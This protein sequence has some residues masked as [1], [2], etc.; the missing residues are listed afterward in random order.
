MKRKPIPAPG[1]AAAPHFLS[2]TGAL[3]EDAISG[4]QPPERETEPFGIYTAPMGRFSEAAFTRIAARA[5]RMPW[6]NTG[7]S[8]PYGYEPLRQTI[9]RRLR[10]WKEIDCS[11]ENIVITA[12]T[13]QSLA[14]ISSVVLEAGDTVLAEDPGYV[15]SQQVLEFQGRQVVPVPLDAQGLDIRLALRRAPQARAALVSAVKQFPAGITMSLERREALLRWA[16]SGNRWIFEDDS[17]NVPWLSEEAAQ[18]LRAMPMG[19][20][21]VFYMESLSFQIFPG[22][23]TGFIVAPEGF[24]AALAGARMM[25]DR[26]QS[27]YR[28]AL[29]A[30][31]LES[32]SYESYLRR[33]GRQYRLRTAFFLRTASRRLAPFGFVQRPASGAFIVLLLAPG[34]PDAAVKRR[35]AGSLVCRALS[36]YGRTEAKRNGLVLGIGS[37][38]EKE[39]TDGVELIAQACRWVR[40]H[41]AC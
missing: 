41:R 16:A 34:I 9:A 23:C 2:K 27:E 36:G 24:Q 18:P 20:Q 10:Q 31:Y 33:L 14:L 19:A 29:L 6:R 37:F 11:E 8:S 30:E 39:I 7:Y 15:R 40:D 32:N 21:A 26:F 3:A 13:S 12:G 35:L 28:Q 38:S 1:A 5:A 25:T 22:I 4:Y 17:H